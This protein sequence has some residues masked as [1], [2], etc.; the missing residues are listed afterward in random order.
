MEVTD[1]HEPYFLSN[2]TGWE[3]YVGGWWS[4]YTNRLGWDIGLLKKLGQ[5]FACGMRHLGETA[6]NGMLLGRE[7]FT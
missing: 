1:D 4:E 6:Q 3:I 5:R 7:M 2:V